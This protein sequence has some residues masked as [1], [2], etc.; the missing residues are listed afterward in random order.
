MKLITSPKKQTELNYA[1]LEYELI[2]QFRPV[3]LFISSPSD[4]G[5]IQIVLSCVKFNYLTIQERVT[6]IFKLINLKCPDIIENRL[7]IIQAF[8]TKQMEDVLIE[9][10][11]E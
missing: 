4:T 8:D 3:F 7:L 1:R 10:F 9:V 6:E 2:I 11:D 5:E